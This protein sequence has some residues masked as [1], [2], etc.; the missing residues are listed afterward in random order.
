MNYRHEPP[1]NFTLPQ[2]YLDYRETV[3]DFARRELQD[4]VITRDAEGTFWREGWQK[5]ADFGIQ[6]LAAPAAYGGQQDELDVFRS[7]VAMEA[8]GYACPDTG[9]VLALNAQM[10]AVQSTIALFGT[11][12]QKAKYLPGMVKGQLFGCHALTETESGSD[13]FTLT[14]TAEKLDGGYRLNGGKRLVTLAPVADVAVVFASTAPERGKWG[15]TAFLVDADS[16]GYTASP[17]RKKMG[18]RTAPFGEITFENCFVPEENRIGKE[19]AGFSIC[20]HSLEYDR[21]CILS[22]KL[23]TMQRQLEEA[24]TFAKKRKQFGKAV[25]E[26]QSV[27]NRIA[28]M[29]MRIEISRL[30]LYRLASL[31]LNGQPSMIESSMLKL[32]L[33]EAFVESSLDA[34]RIGG[35]NAYLTDFGTERDLRDAVGGVLY[36]GTSDIQR[37][38]IAQLTGL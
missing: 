24:V 22:G 17:N 7:V 31:K 27:S 19:G 26:F 14:T 10:W 2:A 35:G 1:V 16:A 12:T 5:C 21:C 38:I 11:E 23:G 4:D 6:G 20:N 13:I 15:I 3:I 36:A 37:N 18:L 34:I 30:L 25:G 8:L 33:S 9:L 32:Y 28:D 29:R